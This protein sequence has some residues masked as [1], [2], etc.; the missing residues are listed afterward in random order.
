MQR[1]WK[2]NSK[3][4]KTKAIIQFFPGL[5]PLISGFSVTTLRVRIEPYFIV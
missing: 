1:L 5:I 4:A 2:K 3:S